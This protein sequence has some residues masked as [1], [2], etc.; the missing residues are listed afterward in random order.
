MASLAQANEFLVRVFEVFTPPMVKMTIRRATRTKKVVQEVHSYN[1]AQVSGRDKLFKSIWRSG[2]G[3]YVDEIQI[4]TVA[5]TIRESSKMYE[6]KPFRTVRFM[7]MDID[8]L[9][10]NPG[11]QELQ[12]VTLRQDN[13]TRNGSNIKSIDKEILRSLWNENS[14]CYRMPLPSPQSNYVQN[15]TKGNRIPR[16]VGLRLSSYVAPSRNPTLDLPP[17]G[18]F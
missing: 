15:G 7:N 8:I 11:D 9:H 12:Q 1:T 18:L 14:E 3:T 5:G 17:P 6:R 4:T 16:G 13:L 10:C 2:T